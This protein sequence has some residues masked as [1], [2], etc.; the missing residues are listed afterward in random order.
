MTAITLASGTLMT[1]MRRVAS[2]ISTL[3]ARGR[4]RHAQ[5]GRALQQPEST[6]RR[7]NDQRFDVADR[8]QNAPRWRTAHYLDVVRSA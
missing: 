1:M 8:F 4:G 5:P 3:S 7:A 6:R 2:S